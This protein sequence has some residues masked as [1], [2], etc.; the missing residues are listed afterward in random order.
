MASMS[1]SNANY[2]HCLTFCLC[3]HCQQHSLHLALSSLLTPSDIIYH[4]FSLS[5]YFFRWHRQFLSCYYSVNIEEFYRQW[6]IV[7]YP[8]ERDMWDNVEFSTDIFHKQ[9]ARSRIDMCRM[10]SESGKKLDHW[11]MSFHAYARNRLPL[12]PCKY[13]IP[14]FESHW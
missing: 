10:V 2:F 5:T 8:T 12:L 4:Q 6:D 11:F 14:S 1:S 7:L 3:R 13:Y 9:Y